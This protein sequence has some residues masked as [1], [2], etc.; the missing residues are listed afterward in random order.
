MAFGAAFILYTAQ[1]LPD[2]LATHFSAD[3]RA[4]G[5]MARRVYIGFSL[6]AL[7]GLP[8]SIAYLLFKLP[9]RL[10]NWTNILYREYWLAPERRKESQG[11]L[12]SHG[13][14]LGCLIVVLTIG[15]HYTILVANRHSPQVL[16]MSTLLS[17]LGAFLIALFLWVMTFY[18]R[19]PKPDHV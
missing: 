16:P 3:G 6:T 12:A 18:R 4:N 2:P 1:Y 11:F 9:R 7:I 13:C 5:W 8:A 14:R 17:L 15:L 10:S 19:F